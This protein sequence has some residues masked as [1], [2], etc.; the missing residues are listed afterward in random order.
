VHV[1][2]TDKVGTEAAFHGLDEYMKN[3]ANFFELSD[4]IKGT[5]T[6]RLVYLATDEIQVLKDARE[7]YPNYQFIFDEEN[8][9][10]AGSFP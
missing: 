8:A 2:R 6:K 9:R 5:K 4:S 7:K 1:R 10:S 3:V